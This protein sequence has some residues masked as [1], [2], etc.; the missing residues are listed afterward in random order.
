MMIKGGGAFITPKVAN[1][2]MYTHAYCIHKTTCSHMRSQDKSG[3]F[4]LWPVD[5]KQVL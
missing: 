2:Y 4:V 5:T 3:G 1:T